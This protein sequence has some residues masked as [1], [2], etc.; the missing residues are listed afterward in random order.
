METEMSP[1]EFQGRPSAGCYV[2]IWGNEHAPVPN[3]TQTSRLEQAAHEHGG[4]LRAL[5]PNIYAVERDSRSVPGWVGIAAFHSSDDAAAWYDP[6]KGWAATALLV[7]AH[8]EPVWWPPERQAERPPWSTQLQPPTDRL[9]VYVSVWVDITDLDTF[10]DYATRFRWTVEAN[11]GASLGS[12][13]A[14]T[15][16]GGGPGPAATPLLAWSDENS[17]RAWYDSADYLPY[18]TQRHASSNATTAAVNALPRHQL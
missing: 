12:A 4:Q 11:Q 16:L 15:V 10:R 9:G 7:P 5:G 13:P 18:R 2:V 14:P 6:F 17:L 3:P 1:Q 8:T